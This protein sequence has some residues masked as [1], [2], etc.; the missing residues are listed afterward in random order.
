MPHTAGSVLPRPWARARFSLRFAAPTALLCVTLAIG[1][2]GLLRSTMPALGHTGQLL[3]AAGISAAPILILTTFWVYLITAQT[4]A[5][6][7]EALDPA[8]PPRARGTLATWLGDGS[9]PYVIE[10]V[11][12]ALR[13]RVAVAEADTDRQRQAAD[14]AAAG[15]VELVSVMMEAEERVRAQ[16][17]ADLHDTVAQELLVAMYRADAFAEDASDG[18]HVDRRVRSEEAAGLAS[19]IRE[20]ERQ[21]RQLMKDARPPELARGNL[22]TAVAGLAADVYARSQVQV[23]V[24]W[25]TIEMAMPIAWATVAYR[26]LQEALRN[27]EKHAGTDKAWVRFH[28]QDGHIVVEVE[29]AG[30]GFSQPVE[31]S[32]SGHHVGVPLMMLRAKALGG[33]VEVASMEGQGTI[34]T[35]TLP[36]PARTAPQA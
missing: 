15:V 4:R 32:A 28:Y 24:T 11:V 19:Q 20:A 29:D 25:P 3:V 9:V 10:D 7:A 6:L 27:V 34:V 1:L 14:A 31:Q 21:L 8:V 22:A 35:L 23:E 33:A 36:I 26:F 18:P 5:V 12:R 13:S 16:I 30:A 17:V 2:P